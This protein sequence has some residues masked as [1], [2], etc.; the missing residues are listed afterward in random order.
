MSLESSLSCIRRHSGDEPT[1]SSLP[2]LRG[3]YRDDGDVPCS[4]DNGSFVAGRSPG[5]ILTPGLS[6][7]TSFLLLV[8]N[9]YLLCSIGY[10]CF[11]GSFTER[12]ILDSCSTAARLQNVLSAGPIIND[13]LG[14][15]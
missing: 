10:A 8:P 2:S 11:V 3:V 1:L 4:L 12:N 15:W 13:D 14:V 5:P 6:S 7:Q 9:I